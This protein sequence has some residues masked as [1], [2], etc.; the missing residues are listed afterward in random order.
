MCLSSFYFLVSAHHMLFI[1]LFNIL[2]TSTVLFF[3]PVLLRCN[4]HATLFTVKWCTV[5][6]SDPSSLWKKKIAK[7]VL[8]T[9]GHLSC[10]NSLQN[11]SDLWKLGLISCLYKFLPFARSLCQEPGSFHL[12][13]LSFLSWI[14]VKR[15]NNPLFSLYFFNTSSKYFMN[16]ICLPLKELV[17]FAKECINFQPF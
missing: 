14:L 12:W 6:W 17:S 5:W 7:L 1:C 2:N 8:V 9:L 4:W 3:L 11:L 15:F 10:S 13:D 16:H